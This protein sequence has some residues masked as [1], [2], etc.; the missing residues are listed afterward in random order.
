MTGTAPTHHLDA[1]DVRAVL[2]GRLAGAPDA[3]AIT[4]VRPDAPDEVYTCAEVLERA[5]AY[6][7][8]YKSLGLEPGAVVLVCLYLSLDLHAAFLGGIL[9][10]HVPSMIAPPSPR[11]ER[12][13]YISSF[14][15]MNEHVTPG[16]VVT[17]RD[18]IDALEEHRPG[19]LDGQNLVDAATITTPM[20]DVPFGPADIDST[21]LDPEL[22]VLLQHSSGTTGMQKGIAL[23]HR[24]VLD[25][26]RSYGSSIKMSP[27]DRIASWLPLYHDM[28]LIA[29]FVTPSLVGTPIIQMSPFDWV[30]RPTLLL[31]TIG[32]H[33]ATLCWLPNF[34]YAFMAKAVRDSQM[35]GLDLTSIRAFINCSEP[36]TAESHDAFLARFGDVGA[37]PDQLTACYAMAENVYAVTQSPL[38]EA[39]RRDA[40]SRRVFEAEHRAA[41]SGGDDLMELVS[42]GPAIDGVRVKITDDDGAELPE[43][44][45]G[46]ILITGSSVF[47]GYFERDDLTEAAFEGEWYN[48]GDLGYLADGELYVTG[49]KKDLIIIQGRNFY[50]TDIEAAVGELEGVSDGRV[51]AFGETDEA[52][53]TEALVVLAESTLEDAALRTRLK[54]SIRKTVA[55][56]FDCTVG[57][58]HVLESRWLVKSTAGKVARADNRVKYE[59]ELRNR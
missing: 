43:R 17:D 14:V 39:P 54:L 27:D 3:T 57:Q 13:K 32:S 15:G 23:S 52:S 22:A 4:I 16:C 33:Q 8:R 59:R 50:P 55:Q 29:C 34:A 1:S 10:G 56:T 53:G 36:V 46:N 47:A 51:A 42:N 7:D 24:V 38:G 9:S 49:R 48:T 30:G 21:P 20:R 35:D 26:V 41:E 45:A 58:I 2:R 25:Q 19:A 12:Q 31:E 44:H 6:A 5:G 37:R 11:M 18:V 40:I 28:G